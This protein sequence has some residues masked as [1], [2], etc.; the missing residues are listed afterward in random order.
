MNG[1][2][3]PIAV[4]IF[5]KPPDAGAVKTRLASA[6]G[7][8]GAARLASA[9]LQ[10]T[11]AAVRACPWAVPIVATTDAH[12]WHPEGA[13]QV[14]PQGGGDLGARVERVLRRALETYPAAVAV[15][16]DSPAT[17]R[18]RLEE[19]RAALAHTTAVVGPTEDGGFDLLALRRCPIG[20]LQDLPWSAPTTCDRTVHQLR[21]RGF[22]V[23]VLDVGFDVDRPEDLARLARLLA[24]AP[25]LAPATWEAL[26]A[27]G[28]GGL[29]GP[30]V[31]ASR[32][33]AG[34]VATD[35]N[36][37]PP[38]SDVPSTAC[39]RTGAPGDPRP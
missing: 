30:G 16:A 6:V 38:P 24:D 17:L 5:A 26:K 8:E 36:E 15:G 4:C 9:L 2:T 10:D 35:C 7:P 20:L 14:W 29:A 39:S 27:L 22:D 25:H 12:G 33:L 28:A 37:S 19:A 31:L 23:Q 34:G 32:P 18:P 11:L 1:P 3:P 13:A 21:A